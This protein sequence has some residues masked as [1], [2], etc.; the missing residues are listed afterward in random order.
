MARIGA[1]H[2]N[3]VR[4][5]VRVRLAKCE[6]QFRKAADNESMKNMAAE[7]CDRLCRARIVEEMQQRRGTLT[8]VHL[9]IVLSVIDGPGRVPSKS[10]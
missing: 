9:K 4:E 7:T 8:A 5:G 10:G 3:V 2:S 1:K 6:G